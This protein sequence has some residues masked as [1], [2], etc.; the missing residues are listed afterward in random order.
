MVQ[1]AGPADIDE[2]R[3]ESANAVFRDVGQK[4]VGQ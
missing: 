3:P 2:V 4:D 1:I